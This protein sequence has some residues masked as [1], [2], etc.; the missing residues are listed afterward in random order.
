MC[1]LMVIVLCKTTTP[2]TPHVMPVHSLQSTTSIVGGGTPRAQ[3]QIQLKICGINWRYFHCVYVACH[4][5][6]PSEQHPSPVYSMVCIHNIR[7]K[8]KSRFFTSIYYYEWLKQGRSEKRGYSI[9]SWI[10]MISVTW[11][12]IVSSLSPSFTRSSCSVKWNPSLRKS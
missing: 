7:R 2:S 5:I 10:C 9:P 8:L 1:T 3:T 4:S 11:S 6:V 12:L